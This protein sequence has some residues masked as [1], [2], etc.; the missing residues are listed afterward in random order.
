MNNVSGRDLMDYRA[1]RAS[2]MNS[3]SLKHQMD[4]LRVFIRWCESYDAVERN[5]SEKVQSPSPGLEERRRDE[6]V[7]AKQAQDALAYLS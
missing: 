6:K 3:V 7:T 2:N 1:S 4:C 5:L